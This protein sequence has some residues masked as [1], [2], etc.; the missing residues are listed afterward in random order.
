MYIKHGFIIFV[1]T[2]FKPVST[3][4]YEFVFQDFPDGSVYNYLARFASV[5]SEGQ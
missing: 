5:F 3:Y 4:T 1:E 2:G